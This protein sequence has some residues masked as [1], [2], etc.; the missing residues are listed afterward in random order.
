MHPERLVVDGLG[1]LPQFAHATLTDDLVFVSG[2]LGTGDGL[3]LVDG[4]V[5]PETAQALANVG[6]ILDAA[7]ATWD[8]V[9]KVSV[10]LDDLDDF[11]AMNAAYDEF[12][13][14]TPPARI[15]LGGVRLALGAR[16]E[17]ECI[18]HRPSPTSVAG[19][20]IPPPVRRTEVVEHDGESLH[21][22]VVG[23]GGVPLVLSHGA[24]GNHA[25]WFQQVASFAADRTVVTWD[26][27]GFGRSTDRAGRSGPEVAVGDL[28]AILDHLGIERADL[29]GQ[30]MGGWTVVGAA[31]SRP[32]LA[33]SL[34]LAD[35]L[36]GFT[37]DPI[38]AALA[39][40]RRVE[41]A[42]LDAGRLGLHPALDT[43]F[44]TRRP[45]LAHLYQS[46]GAMGS[47][48]MATILPRLLATTHEAAE[49]ATIT[50]P[51]LCVV[52][53][54]DPLFPPA[55]VRAM[56]DL[57]PDARVVELPGCGHSPYFEDPEAWNL[58]VGRFLA[59]VA[60]THAR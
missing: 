28:L 32:G 30:S 4:G 34:V 3:T 18:A 43:G 45:E 20:A 29:V 39:A 12:F 19:G 35:T 23:E 27:R 17:L 53:D 1:R 8:D 26:H 46:L 11:A 54:R 21:V 5:G 59:E 51:V 15:T 7:G 60:R 33:R 6:R 13:T 41:A 56:A 22:E 55:S 36:G 25:V 10:Y 9:V 44:S 58:V 40:P 31:L 50:C 52:G 49:A 24:G 14:D 48:D 47:A 2:T 42:R 37:S 38:A 57:L 16:V